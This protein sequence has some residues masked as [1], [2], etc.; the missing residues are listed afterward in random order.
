MR[1]D[2][3]APFHQAKIFSLHFVVS[4]ETVEVFV[5]VGFFVCWF[6]GEYPMD[7]LG[8]ELSAREVLYR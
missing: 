3:G 8:M 5:V 7:G 6:F 1:P 2:Y 4:E